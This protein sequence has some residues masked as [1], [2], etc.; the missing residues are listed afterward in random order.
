MKQTIDFN[1]FVNAFKEA[2][3]G[4]Q[5]SLQGLRALFD[6]LE[7]YEE[8]TGEELELDVIALCCEFTESTPK[9]VMEAYN[10]EGGTDVVQYLT[11][12]D[13]FVASLYNDN[14]IYSNF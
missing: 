7:D 11:N 4:E 10:L 9:E 8:S 12:N 3:R 6:Y 5:F 1:D 2:D 13:V 14:V